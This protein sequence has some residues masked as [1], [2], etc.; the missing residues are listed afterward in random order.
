LNPPPTTRFAG[1]TLTFRC[2]T[3]DER[4]DLEELQR[5]TALASAEYGQQIL[6]NP[7]AIHIPPEAVQQGHARAAIF[8]GRI[9]GFSLVL[10]TKP[11]TAE[12]DGLFVEPAFMEQGLGRA[13]VA[14]AV[15]IAHQQGIKSLEVTSNPR[16]IGFYEKLGFIGD[17]P[18]AT[19]FDRALRMHLDLTRQRNSTPAPFGEI[20]TERLRLLRIYFRDFAECRSDVN[21]FARRHGATAAPGFTFIQPAD[22]DAMVAIDWDGYVM[23]HRESA[24]LMGAC[25]A[26]KYPDPSGGVEIAYGVAPEF[27]GKGLATEAARALSAQVLR[28][29]E[30]R[31]VFACTLPEPNASTRVLTKCGFMRAG[32]TIDPD[33]GVVWKWQLTRETANAPS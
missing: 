30:V 19:R 13:L 21:A 9:I 25:G 24:V 12:L 15:A 17:G 18:V 10:P 6:A 23:I 26:R 1:A 29:P 20:N 3:A 11:A 33:E 16:A 2:A 22:R 32:D 27:Q 5:R 7:D 31:Y 4:T 14:D 8:E 28:R